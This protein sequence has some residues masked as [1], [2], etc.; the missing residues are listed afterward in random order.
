V[1]LND[2]VE[3]ERQLSEEKG[4]TVN[5]RKPNPYTL[6]MAAEGLGEQGLVLYV[7]DSMEDALMARE[8]SKT[9]REFVFVGVYRYSGL[10]DLVRDG[11][12]GSGCDI[13]IP[14]V[15]ELPSLLEVI[16]RG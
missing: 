4:A 15:N 6:T 10:D 3:A 7:G 13:V 11:F 5:L 16:R 9:G 12:L 14:S 1:F 2:A 8:A